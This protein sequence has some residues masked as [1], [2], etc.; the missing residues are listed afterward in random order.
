MT[1]DSDRFVTLSTLD[2][3]RDELR[4]PETFLA[5]IKRVE[6]LEAAVRVKAFADVLLECDLQIDEEGFTTDHDKLVGGELAMAAAHYA[7]Y[8]SRDDNTRSFLNIQQWFPEKFP[9][10]RSWWKPKDRRR[11]L[12]RAAGL[13]IAEIKRLDR[14]S[15]REDAQCR[16]M[17]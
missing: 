1:K 9:F 16:R 7:A 11:D 8:A 5:L 14:K 2:K 6:R 17:F 10:D 4:A 3:L 12:V 15:K 13:I